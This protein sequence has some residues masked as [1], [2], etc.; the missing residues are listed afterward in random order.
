MF[1]VIACFHYTNF[2]GFK[3]YPPVVNFCIFL[4]FF[5]S[6][7]QEKTVI[8]KMALLMEPDANEAV[9]T[10]TRNLTYVWAVF[11]FLNFLV[12]LATVFSS[13]KIWAI[14]NGF[15][16]YVLVGLVFI[17][18]YIIRGNFKKKYGK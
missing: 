7:F 6:I 12:S 16:S 10:Y 9:M 17:I 8:Q 5:T 14:Y 11:T 2:V 1:V 15:I 4:I 18:E 3:F 13:E